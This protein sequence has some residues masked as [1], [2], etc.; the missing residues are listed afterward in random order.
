MAVTEVNICLQIC[1]LS[2]S[3]QEGTLL[4]LLLVNV[5]VLCAKWVLRPIEIDTRQGAS[6]SIDIAKRNRDWVFQC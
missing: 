5:V 1:R 3:K 4:H 6:L 2:H